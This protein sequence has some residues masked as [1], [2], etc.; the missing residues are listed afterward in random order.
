MQSIRLFT[1][2]VELA[3]FSAVAREARLGQ[4][5]VSKIISALERNLGVRLLERTTTAVTLTEEGRRFYER[6]NR[7]LEEYADAVADIRGLKQRCAGTL[8]ISSPVGLGELRL[9]TLFLEFLEKY[10]EIEIELILNDRMV[11]LVEEGVDVAIRLG[12]QLPPSAVA[13]HIASSPRV[14]VASPGY[15][16]TS[17]K[18]RRP[19]DLEKHQYIRFAGTTSGHRLEFSNGSEKILVPTRGRYRV[20][21]SLALRQC[22][23][24]GTGMGTA[25]AWLVQDLIDTG[26]LIQ[27]LPNWKLAGQPVHLIYPSRR[28]LP[29]RSRALLQFMA[30]KIPMLPGFSSITTLS[31]SPVEC[32]K[33]F[34]PKY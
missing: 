25:P 2:V 13:R 18:V 30:E 23:L 8:L 28:Y 7:V 34:L 12:D 33:A 4:P 14:L 1:R 6:S 5:T 24:Q 32:E 19:E 3:S 26:V 17:P 31:C 22:F 15:L 21:N 27:L 11:D 20:N 29:L 10:P 9:N 16:R